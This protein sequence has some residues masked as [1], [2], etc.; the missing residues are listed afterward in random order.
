MSCDLALPAVHRLLVELLAH[1]EV[2]LGGS[3]AGGRLDVELLTVLPDLHVRVGGG[4]HRHLPQHGVDAWPPQRAEV[5]GQRSVV[6]QL[7]FVHL[8]ISYLSLF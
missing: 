7:M 8:I 6:F 4:R 2:D 3:D 5:R 1:V